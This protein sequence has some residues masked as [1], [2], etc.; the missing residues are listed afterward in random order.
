MPQIW[1]IRLANI[2]Y[3]GGKKVYTDELFRLRGK[4]GLINLANGGG[5]TLLVQL[6]LQ[7]VLPNESFNKRRVVDLLANKRYTGHIAVE[8]RLD[9]PETEFLTTGFCF[10]RG[11]EEDGRLRYFM[12]TIQYTQPNEFDVKNLPLVKKQV[13]VAYAELLHLLRQNTGSSEARIS[14]FDQDDKYRAYWQELRTFN[15]FGKEWKNIKTINNRE[16]GVAEFFSGASTTKQLLEHLIIPAVEGAIFDSEKEAQELTQSFWQ[17]YQ[18]LMRIPE[19]QK[20]LESFQVL[21]QG[22]EAV[23]QEVRTYARSSDQLVQVKQQLGQLFGQVLTELELT[24]TERQQVE[25]QL[26]TLSQRQGQLEYQA[27]SLEHAR[28][29]RQLTEGRSKMAE[30]E[31]SLK[32]SRKQEQAAD[33]RWRLAKGQ[34][35]FLDIQELIG[36]IKGWEQAREIQSQGHEEQLAQLDSYRATVRQRLTELQQARQQQYVELTTRQQQHQAEQTSL[37]QTR[38]ALLAEKDQLSRRIGALHTQKEH[39]SKRYDEMWQTYQ[40]LLWLEDP[41]AALTELTAEL[42]RTQDQWQQARQEKEELLAAEQDLTNQL[43]HQDALIMRQQAEVT[44][45]EQAAQDY[46]ETLVQVQEMLQRH[47]ITAKEPFAERSRLESQLL[48]LS[49]TLQAQ[50]T[51]EGAEISRLEEQLHL[52]TQYDFYVP[53]YELLALQKTLQEI[54]VIAKPGSQWLQDLQIEE[55]QRAAYLRHN[56]LLPYALV[57]TEADFK[58]LQNRRGMW[59]ELVLNC[60]VPLVVRSPELTPVETETAGDWLPLDERNTYVVWHKGYRYAVSPALLA[61]EQPGLEEQLERKNQI[62]ANLR[63][64]QEAVVRTGDRLQQFY[65]T[66]TV[67]SANHIQEQLTHTRQVLAESLST[68]ETMETRQQQLQERRPQLE[69]ELEKLRERLNQI[70]VSQQ[71]FQQWQ[72]DREQQLQILTELEQ[73]RQL[74]KQQQTAEQELEEKLNR[75]EQQIL[76]TQGSISQLEGTLTQLQEKLV[77]TPHPNQPAALVLDVPYEQA[78][79][80]LK[81]LEKQVNQAAS[82]ITAYDDLISRNRQQIAK[83]ERE[84]QKELKLTLEEVAEAKQRTTEFDLDRLEKEVGELT[85]RVEQEREAVRLQND[86]VLKMEGQAEERT[87]TIWKKYGQLPYAEFGDLDRDAARIK[88]DQQETE[89]QLKE[90]QLRRR[91]VEESENL[92]DKMREKLQDNLSRFKVAEAGAPMAAEEWAQ[93][94]PRLRLVVEEQL[95]RLEA[96]HDRIQA[97]REQVSRA[98]RQYTQVLK[99]Q[100]NQVLNKF[101]NHLLADESRQFDLP[102]IETSFA[103]CFETLDNYEQKVRYDLQEC[104]RHKQLLVERCVKQAERIAAEIKTIDR[105]VKVDYAGQTVSAVQIKL[106][107]WEPA[108]APVLMDSHL[109]ACILKLKEMSQEPVEKLERYIRNQL[110]SRQLLDVLANLNQGVVKVLKPDEHPVSPRYDQWD[111]VEKWSGGERFAGYMAMFMAILSYT[112]SKL[113]SLRN[114]HKVLVADNPFGAASSAHVLNLVFQIAANNN[115]QM[116]C[117]TALT[118]ETIFSYFP[119]VYSLKL[120]QF[121][122]KDYIQ[123]Q[124][125]KGFYQIDPLEEEL[126][127]RRQMTLF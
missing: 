46:Q 69:A 103:K 1:R 120:R 89:R 4:N 10:T 34:N 28:L 93:V 67:D 45:A 37:K 26:G 102:A 19:L 91:Q 87:T 127:R 11:A 105:Y 9:S 123:S 106:K 35:R 56:P 60:P 90:T 33:Y 79:S 5:K 42:A 6:L 68:R 54:G 96:L 75:L 18:S 117:L 23:L 111:N 22:G 119:V 2:E 48:S 82:Q 49:L 77:N 73:L 83:L 109:E 20:N 59:R 107:D 29:F 124:M 13:P 38:T 58:Q 63:L 12:Y 98:Y 101:L 118:E 61:L 78:D 51:R 104:E 97:Q 24:L 108:N 92:L 95:G 3:D 94:K 21:R 44:A 114:P 85:R 112:R 17:Y 84:I 8:W 25:E 115:I 113:S 76:T 66:Y 80:V 32:A 125:E 43:R 71:H 47:S 39:Y 52:L 36:E 126:I 99:E 64:S 86:K 31:N 81:E 57:L 74:E 15:I 62:L 53:N 65:C 50:Q 16:G 70:E 122:G 7:A 121:M 40:N 14:V 27:E 88:A 55:A 110:S 116:L 30:L 72:L 41:A 100:N